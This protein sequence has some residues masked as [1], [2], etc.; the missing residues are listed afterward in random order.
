MA[1]YDLLVLG[2]GSGSQVATAAVNRGRE[3]AVVEPGPLGGACITRGCVPS[4]ALLHRADVRE[5]LRHTDRIGIDASV[6]GIDYGAITDAI[7]E[8]VYTKAARQEAALEA[9][10]NLD[11]YRGHGRFVTDHEVLIKEPTGSQ[12]QITA[13]QLVIAVG[14]RP[15]VPPIEGLE[16]IDFLTSDNALYLDERPDSLTIVGGGYIGAELGYFFA[17]MDTDVT[18]I[19]RSDRLLSREDPAVADAV[20][21]SLSVYCDCYTGYEAT[22]VTQANGEVDLE[23]TDGEETVEVTSDELLVA[24]GRRPN[25]DTL[26]LEK[27]DIEVDESGHVQTDATLE[28]SVDGVWALGDVLAP[29]P[30]KHVADR[31]AEVVATNVLTED[32]REIDYHGTPHAIFTDPP[33]ASVGNTEADLEAEGTAYE[34]TRMPY[35]A[36]PKGRILAPDHGFVKVLADPDGAILGC[37]V[38]GP[39]APSLIQEVVVAMA[40]GEGTVDEVADTV[41]VHPALSEVILAAFEAAADRLFATPPDWRA[42]D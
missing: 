32:T 18:I 36:A 20:T 40:C 30:Y 27:T 28:T 38:V 34:V 10:P 31:E 37:H 23:A 14:G 41:H 16:E 25:T 9:E 13:D 33:V 3:A 26:A 1:E 35:E 21:D 24:A 39:N 6:A 29:A 12:S 42:V 17:A 15:T 5:Q 2:G 8:L 11:L 4:K 22:A 19:S 7:E